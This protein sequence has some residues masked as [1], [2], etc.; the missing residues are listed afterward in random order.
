[1]CMYSPLG[2]ARP[3]A[4]C[5]HI[6]QCTPAFV[7]TITCRLANLVSRQCSIYVTAVKVECIPYTIGCAVPVVV[8]SCTN[9]LQCKKWH[10]ESI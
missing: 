10:L 2:A 6:R 1:M 5:V 3:R 7:T 4:L 9:L 8:M